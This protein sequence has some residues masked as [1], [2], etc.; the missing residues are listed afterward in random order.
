VPIKELKTNKEYLMVKKKEESETPVVTK[1]ASIASLMRASINSEAK[2]IFE[3]A[4]KKDDKTEF[5]DVAMNPKESDDLAS[6]KDFIKMKPFFKICIGV[7][8]FP[9]GGITQ[10]IGKSD[11][12]KTSLLIQGMVSCQQSGGVVFF[13]DAENKFPWD[14]FADMGGV[15]E[16]VVA[17][18]VNS[19]EEAWNVWWK[20]CKL[21]QELR[22]TGQLTIGESKV[23]LPKDT[24]IM[25]AWDSVA[26]S[27]AD[28]ILEEEDAGD[29]HVMVEARINN[30]NVRKLKKI[31]RTAKVA[32]V[33]INH[34]YMTNPMMGPPEEVIKGGEEMFFM[35]TLI[36][37]MIK[38]AVIDREVTVEGK[39]YK[40]KI[41]RKIRMEVFKGHMSGR[42][43]QME[44]NACAP[45]ILAD[46]EFAEY[47]KSIQG[48]L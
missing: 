35:S 41:G 22:E 1:S 37:K 27:V 13:I 47:R 32:A 9:E 24:K 42:Y 2:K 16:D 31:I 33:F 18:P 6:I 34:S 5:K 26:G 11:S 48:Q 46:E 21:I 30:K 10:I 14:R 25:A 36:I 19:L 44:L 8:G 38:G 43:T 28:K 17:F 12:G 23:D 4:K 40:Q 15:I 39:K 20:I 3:K 29:S 45:G 7:D